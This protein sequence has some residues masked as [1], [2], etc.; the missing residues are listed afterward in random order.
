VGA[1][2][3]VVHFTNPWAG[4]FDRP[5]VPLGPAPESDQT[6][7]STRNPKGLFAGK[8]LRAP[9]LN[10]RP[11]EPTGVSARSLWITAPRV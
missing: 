3:Q 8:W 9:D 6:A 4:R 1:L 2:R 10:Q 11:A 5:R 7:I